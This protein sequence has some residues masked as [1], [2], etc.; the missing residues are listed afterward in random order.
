MST[1]KDVLI[2]T[3]FSCEVVGGGAVHPTYPLLPV[4]GLD[5]NVFVNDHYP[6]RSIFVSHNEQFAN[7]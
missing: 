4:P 1:C 3:N 5:S 2:P 7:F 6:I